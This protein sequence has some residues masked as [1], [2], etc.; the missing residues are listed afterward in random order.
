VES[1]VLLSNSV[2]RLGAQMWAVMQNKT[3]IKG[4]VA[5]DSYGFVYPD[6]ANITEV[7]GRFLPVVV[8]LEDFKKLVKVNVQF[9]WEDYRTKNDTRLTQGLWSS[10]GGRGNGS[11]ME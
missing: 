11:W 1:V 9:V 6:N 7:R 3:D 10:K 5:Y 2:A 4:I 8:P